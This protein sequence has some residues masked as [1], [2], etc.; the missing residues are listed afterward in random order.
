MGIHGVGYE[1]KELFRISGHAGCLGLL[2]RGCTKTFLKFTAITV[3]T[4]PQ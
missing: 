2:E 4:L 1:T 3:K